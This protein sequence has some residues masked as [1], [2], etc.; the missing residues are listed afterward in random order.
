MAKA[1]ATLLIVLGGINIVNEF[2][3]AFP[4]KLKIPA[5]AHSKM[6]GLMNKASMPT[7]FL[8]DSHR[9]THGPLNRYASC[10]Y[11]ENMLA[12]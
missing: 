1:G 5:A 7:A 9:N 4:I 10:I 8:A 11:P 6:A 2:F 12:L 3:P